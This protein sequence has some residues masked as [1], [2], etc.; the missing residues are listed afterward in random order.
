MG[1]SV[2]PADI[3]GYV[4]Q[5]YTTIFSAYFNDATDTAAQ[6]DSWYGATTAWAA[7]SSG[8]GCELNS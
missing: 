8:P 3:Y 5:S 2:E 1:T 4:D 6:Y 7:L